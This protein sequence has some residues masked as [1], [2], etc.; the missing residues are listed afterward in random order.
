MRVLS[1]RPRD[2]GCIHLAMATWGATGLPPHD[3]FER[4]ADLHVSHPRALSG[5]NYNECLAVAHWAVGRTGEALQFLQRARTL[6]ATKPARVES[7]WRFLTVSPAE[8]R[9]DLDSIA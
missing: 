3:L 8:F 4:V 7:C 1:R 2:R 5:L 9:R 6:I